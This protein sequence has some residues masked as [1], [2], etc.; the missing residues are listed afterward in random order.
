M[1]PRIGITM[2]D[3]AGIGP[4]IIVKA[5]TN[6]NVYQICQPI[7]IGSAVIIQDALRFI[8]PTDLRSESQRN[9]PNISVVQSPIQTTA[10]PERIDVLDVS[11]LT[12]DMFTHGTINPRCGTAAVKAIEAAVQLTLDGMLDGI[13]T[14]PICKASIQRAGSPFPGHTE[15]LTSLTQSKKSV[16]MLKTWDIPPQFVSG[17]NIDSK[18]EKKNSC[19]STNLKEHL[20]VSFVTSHIPIAEVSQKLSVERINDVI[21]I[22]HEALVQFGIE[23]PRL[24]VAGLNPHASEEGM[25]GKEEDT[26]I[27]PAI[28]KAHAD[29]YQVEGPLPADTL[30]KKA[31]RGEWDAVIAM[32][33]DQGNIPIKLI[34]FGQVVNIT[35]GLPI[36]RTSVDHG[37]AFDIAGQGIASETSLIAALAAAAQLASSQL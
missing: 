8:S 7:V 17:R 1:L 15:M 30:F 23:N 14:A 37:T 5:L 25:F 29:G 6:K 13:T 11:S 31:I 35:L 9:L 19:I 2:G 26:C 28:K 16:M 18:K 27:K 3:A 36:V 20:T 4:E 33:H 12:P 34:G 10:I 24:V 32:Y 21:R 22:T